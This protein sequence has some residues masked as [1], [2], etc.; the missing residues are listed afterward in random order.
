[1]VRIGMLLADRV[2]ELL[3]HQFTCFQAVRFG[4]DYTGRVGEDAPLAVR[5]EGLHNGSVRASPSDPI[6]FGSQPA[7]FLQLPAAVYTP[8]DGV[9]DHSNFSKQSQ[10]MSNSH[11]NI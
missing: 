9:F 4:E 11:S 3:G 1:M 6:R 10:F 8:L 7:F 5:G 2:G